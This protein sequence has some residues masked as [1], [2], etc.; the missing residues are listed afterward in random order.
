M[1]NL[2][3]KKP[4]KNTVIN[5]WLSRTL[6]IIFVPCYTVAKLSA[7]GRDYKKEF[8]KLGMNS[9]YTEKTLFHTDSKEA[10]VSKLVIKEFMKLVGTD[11]AISIEVLNRFMGKDKNSVSRTHP[12]QTYINFTLSENDYNSTL[13]SRLIPS[14]SSSY[15]MDSTKPYEIVIDKDAFFIIMNAN[16]FHQFDLTQKNLSR[17]LCESLLGFV[18]ESFV[19]QS[20]FYKSL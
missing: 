13:T 9:M 16:A 10:D 15:N 17:E 4:V 5:K 6:P 7:M 11:E 18:D 12:I 1:I 3:E 14:L 20:V 2:Y 19:F 8:L